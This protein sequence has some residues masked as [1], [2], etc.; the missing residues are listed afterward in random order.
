MRRAEDITDTLDLQG[1]EAGGIRDAEFQLQGVEGRGDVYVCEVRSDGLRPS[2][3]TGNLQTPEFRKI[4]TKPIR[5]RYGTAWPKYE[6]SQV[7]EVG[8]G[9]GED[10]EDILQVFF[11]RV[12][13]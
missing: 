9:L 5:E 4:H 1:P 7:D 6:E 13:V 3:R 11:S 8:C 12:F 2:Y 10:F